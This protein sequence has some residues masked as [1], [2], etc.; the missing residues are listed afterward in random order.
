MV[1]LIYISQ[2]SGEDTPSSKP[3]LRRDQ[4]FYLRWRLIL[5]E[6]TIMAL[7]C[8]GDVVLQGHVVMG[9]TQIH[10]RIF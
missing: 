4:A 10:Q 1:R 6:S 7:L 5:K 8:L 3:S 9:N 2:D